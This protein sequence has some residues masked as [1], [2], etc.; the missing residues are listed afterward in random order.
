MEHNGD[1]DTT[2]KL[3]CLKLSKTHW[4]MKVP[5]ISFVIAAPEIMMVLMIPFVIGVF[6][7]I[8]KFWNMKGPVIP[9]IIGTPEII[10]KP[11]EHEGVGDPFVI[12]AP[13][14]ILTPLEHDGAGDTIGI[15]ALET[16]CKTLELLWC[17]WYYF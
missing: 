5:V 4:N 12:G 9:C 17:C 10:P 14:I 16:A 2:F 6:K 15:Y 13:V 8:P 11:V 3:E 7:T 1:G